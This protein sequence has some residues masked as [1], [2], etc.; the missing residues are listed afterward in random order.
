MAYSNGLQ[1][2]INRV[3][4][5]KC[6]GRG[7]TNKEHIA[8]FR[9]IH[10][11]KYNYSLVT[12]YNSREKIPII[13]PEHGLFFQL[14]NSHLRHGCPKCASEATAESRLSDVRNV[15][16]DFV[17]IHGDTYDYSNVVY[18]GNKQKVSII[19]PEHGEFQILPKHHKNGVGCGKCAGR[20]FGTEKH[21]A[22]FKKVHGDKYDYS[23]VD[24][25]GDASPVSI[26]CPD[27]GVFRQLPTHHK[28]AVGCP[29]CANR[30]H[31]ALYIWTDD[32]GNHKIGVTKLTKG[33]HRIY[34]CARK[35]GTNVSK[36][37]IIQVSEAIKHETLLHKTFTTVPY[38]RGDGWTEFR[39]LTNEEYSEVHAYFDA[40][41]NSPTF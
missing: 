26:V 11:D 13:C 2:L 40:I 41:E 29:A 21:V 8:K 12:N 15:I 19:C 33:N 16:G 37:R 18:K 28:R 20:G 6:A 39:T 3:G 1:T 17:R 7:L 30:D 24:Y 14:Y 34:D 36:L 22:D 25:Q 4:D 9:K 10:G 35:R 31:D 27:H 32:N 23:M 5:A 38:T